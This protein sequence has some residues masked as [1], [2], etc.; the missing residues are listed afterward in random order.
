MVLYSEGSTGMLSKI[1]SKDR[2]AS[3]AFILFTIFLDVLGIGLII[4]VLP[5]LIGQF[6]Q[7]ADEQT[8]W[9]GLLAASYGVVQFFCTPLLGALSDRFGRRPLLLLSIF[10]LGVSY[11]VHA[12]AGS[13]LALFLVR[14]VSGSTAAS[15]AVANAYMADIT[16][17]EKRGKAFGLLGAA[18]GMGFIF[19][20]MMGGILGDI[21]V[22]LPF[23]VAAG[24][25]L[26]NWLYGYFVLP[27]SLPVE[28]RAPFSLA[29]ANPFS[30]LLHLGKLKGVGSLIG[31]FALAVFAQFILQTTFVLYTQFRFGWGPRDNGIA[32]FI[33]GLVGAIVQGGLQGRLLKWLGETRLVLMGLMSATIAYA[34][35]GVID[36]GWMM[37]CVIFGNFLSFGTGPA[38]QSI[39]SKAVGP[40][41]QGLT[42]GSLTAINSVAIIFAPLAG[43]A[44]L[45]RVSHL[46][47]HDWRLG[48]SFY[49]CSALQFCALLFAVSHFRRVAKNPPIAASITP[50]ASS[51]DAG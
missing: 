36:A 13:L 10:G 4:P 29:R 17:A 44:I 21:S 48:A 32:L 15:F 9:F 7:G 11:L 14:I 42:Q 31:V 38:L 37:Y 19:G 41:E 18:F 45:S 43:T 30:A 49:L 12:L 47:G 50:E 25:A 1:F 5:V 16:P 40:K 33:V 34:L 27:E 23:F 24:L 26:L 2:Q 35:Y 39:V 51:A 3:Q 20:P 28:R 22:R 46:P 8:H 6:T